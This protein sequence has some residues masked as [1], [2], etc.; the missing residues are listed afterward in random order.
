MLMSA[1][2]FFW[3]FTTTVLFNFWLKKVS[4]N[5]YPEKDNQVKDNQVK[6]NQLER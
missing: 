6:D 3:D 2:I 5:K 1:K 4:G